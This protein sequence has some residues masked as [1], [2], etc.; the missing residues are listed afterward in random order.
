MHHAK[1]HDDFT[2]A[3][4]EKGEPQQQTLE[5][6]FQQHKKFPKDSRKATKITN[7]TAELILLN[8]GCTQF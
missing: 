3:K 1:E 7:K 6:A 2:K 5:T 8:C 4:M